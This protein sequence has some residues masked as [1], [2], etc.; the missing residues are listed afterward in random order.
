MQRGPID[1]SRA[2]ARWEI[3]PPTQVGGI[4]GIVVAMQR[5]PEM[6]V[7]RKLA[8][9][10]S[11]STVSAHSIAGWDTGPRLVGGRRSGC[12]SNTRY[13]SGCEPSEV[14]LGFWRRLVAW[15]GL[16]PLVI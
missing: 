9:S 8:T 3:Y 10:Q 7:G 6:N 2:R 4:V 15:N 12:T 1:W 13:R 14:G 16:P 11:G 5:C